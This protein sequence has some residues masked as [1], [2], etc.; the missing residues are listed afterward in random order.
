MKHDTLQRLMTRFTYF[1]LY[2]HISTYI[3]YIYIC[4][5]IFIYSYICIGVFECEFKNVLNHLKVMLTLILPLN[6]SQT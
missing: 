6:L 5:Y 2:L 4:I 3:S 1:Y